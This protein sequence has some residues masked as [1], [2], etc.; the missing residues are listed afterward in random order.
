MTGLRASHFCY[1][2]GVYDL[3]FLPWLQEAGIVSATTCELGLATSSSNPQL[4]PRLVDVTGLSSIEFEGW[5]D[6]DIRSITKANKSSRSKKQPENNK[7]RAAPFCWEY[8]GYMMHLESRRV[9]CI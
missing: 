3:R 6:R 2:S 8:T 9:S 4:L 1:P 5:A 7:R